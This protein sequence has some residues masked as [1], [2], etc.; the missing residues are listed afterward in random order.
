VMAYLYKHT[1]LQNNFSVNMTCLVPDESGAVQPQRLGLKD[2]LRHFLDFRFDTVKRRFEF[3]LE[4]LRKRIHILEGF[5]IIFDALDRAIKMIRESEGKADAAEKLIRAFKLDA[6]QA[7]AILDSQLYKIAQLEIQKILDELRDK[8]RQAEKI[9]AILRSKAKLWDTVKDELGKIAEEHGGR[10]R[11]RIGSSDDMLDFDPE[12]YIVRENTNVVVTR[13][14]WIKRVG[15]LASIETTRV[16]EG[17]AVL[18]VVPGSTLD[19]VVFFADDG[20]AF[21]MRLTDVPATTGYGDPLTKFFKLDDQVRIV[22]AASTDT[23]FMPAEVKGKKD[24]PPGP[25]L[26]TVTQQGMTLRTPFAPFRIA[27][28]KVGRRYAKLN[29]GDRVVMATVLTGEEESILL[30]SADGRVLHFAIDEINVLAGVGKGV[31]GIKLADEDKCLGGLLI[32]K[33]SQALQIET[34]GGKTMEFTGRYEIVARG[35]RGFE[36][37]KRTSFVR[38]VPPPI[39]LVDWEQIEGKGEA[40]NGPKNGNGLFE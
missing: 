18:A 10:R 23:R 6:I 9:E 35:G 3:D 13:D 30:A 5:R 36:A 12:A 15:R 14:G 39:E 17:D 33:K 28:T 8:T 34:S 2:V 26:L 19:H 4:Q 20:A 38:I 31:I 32:T 29:E 16:R 7:D 1:E 40:K 21:T 24:E 25:Y 22:A 27:S 11:T 37:V